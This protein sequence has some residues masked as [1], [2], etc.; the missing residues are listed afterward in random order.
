MHG[1]TEGIINRLK[2]CTQTGTVAGRSAYRTTLVVVSYW[3]Y[4]VTAFSLHS[5]ECLHT[6]L[7]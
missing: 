2:R 5:N 1:T 6:L 3:G 7:N 4:A